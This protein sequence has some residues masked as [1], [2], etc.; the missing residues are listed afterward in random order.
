MA[1][2]MALLLRFLEFY[3]EA[4]EF[5]R[6]S[7]RIKHGWGQQVCK[8]SRVLAFVLFDSAIALMNLEADLVDLFA[9][10]HHRLDAFGDHRFGN[11]IS[12]DA[13]ELYFF[14]AVQAHLVRQL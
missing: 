11:V 9:I 2:L 10:D 6:V 5:R 14:S 1:W 4:L 8:R 13:G 3:K 7:V 12:A